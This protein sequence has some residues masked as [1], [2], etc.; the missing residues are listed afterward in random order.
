[1]LLR[2]DRFMSHVQKSDSGCWLWNAYRNH[3][4]YGQLTVCPGNK[5]ML[6]HRVS[7]LL[8]VGEIPS[9][10]CVLHKCDVPACVNPDHLF[11]GTKKRNSED[12][13]AKGRAAG[14]KGECHVCSKLREQDVVEILKSRHVARKELANQFNVTPRTI[15]GIW[16][17]EI[18]RHVNV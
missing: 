4:G 13:V 5:R 2:N 3:N 1:M 8:H 7:Y 12:M 16:S 10:L 9:G 11:I 18:W 14:A 15:N 17:R 6:A